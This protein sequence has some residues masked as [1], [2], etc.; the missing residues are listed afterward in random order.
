M[1]EITELE[2]RYEKIPQELK[3]LR[4]W[5]CFIE[6]VQDGKMVKLPVSPVK[7][8]DGDLTYG[9]DSWTDFDGALKYCV[10]NDLDGLGFEL[11]GSGMFGI[12][13]YNHQDEN[14]N[15]L[16]AQEFQAM[17]N[18]FVKQ[19]DS[20][21]EWSQSKNGIHII[22]YGRLPNGERKGKNV[23]MYDGTIFFA[24]TGNS[25]GRRGVHERTAEVKPL[26]E[27]YVHNDPIDAEEKPKESKEMVTHS[28][29]YVMQKISSSKYAEKI[30]DLL[31][32]DWEKHYKTK[33]KAIQGLCNFLAYYT[34]CNAD[35]IDRLFRKSS[36][37]DEEQWANNGEFFIQTAIEASTAILISE[38]KPTSEVSLKLDKKKPELNIDEEGEPIFR[39]DEEAVKAKRP[40]TLDDTGNAL[41]FHDYFGKHFHYNTDDK[42]YMF[43]TGKTWISDSKGVIRKYANQIIRLLNE[44]AKQTENRIAECSD[45]E[46]AK[47]LKGIYYAQQRNIKRVS[48]KTGKDAMIAELQSL[49]KMP[50][51]NV[52][53]DNDKYLL[54][55]ESGIVDLRTG[56]L[57]PWDRDRLMAKNTNVKVSF[58]EP[59]TFIKF[60]HGIFERGNEQETEEII[61]CLQR[62]L[63]YTLTGLTVEQV[64]F[65]L[66]GDGSNGKSTLTAVIQMIMG[67]YYK[68][69]DS[70]QLMASGKQNQ[71]VAVQYS[72]AELVGAR[73]VITQESDKGARLSASVMKGITSG[74]DL[75]NAQKKYGAPFAYLP[76]FTIWF[77]T[78]Y[79]PNI[80]EKD[81]GTWRRIV[82][83]PFERKFKE[84]EKDK[85]MPEKLKKE[86]PKILGWA[87]KGAVAYLA[88]KDLLIPECLKKKLN[89]YK[90]ENDGTLKFLESD[91]HKVEMGCVSKNDL[92]NAYKNWAMN[93]KEYAL[94]ESQFRSEVVK[95]GYLININEKNGSMYYTGLELNIDAS[96]AKTGSSF[97]YDD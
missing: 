54:N 19:L 52:E 88:N 50:I 69:I 18:E 13:I 63:G 11:E 29:E 90:S 7:K 96:T 39:M 32:G 74:Q 38:N 68:S 37:Y 64:M 14:G 83:F 97:Y 48:N 46:E 45:D 28:D 53:L 43:W 34:N 30:K 58:E 59:K 31:N 71:N 91:T 1:A 26:W 82:V 8:Q 2:K 57:L 10:E 80:R 66:N 4:R 62:C 42:K 87:I 21:S 35:Q 23:A 93:N 72:L 51:T 65:F 77:M 16:P 60:L 49:G 85:D 33:N 81:Y 75:I 3:N 86:Y 84:E 61:T 17:A 44:E 92:Y 5:V 56:E 20:Y 24:M 95:L 76:Q 70:A 79:L 41:R 27:K 25:I 15:S 73:C 55:T 40:Y 9:E 94:P 22:C 89:E 12:D 47:Q 67:D 78:N 6:R 36:L